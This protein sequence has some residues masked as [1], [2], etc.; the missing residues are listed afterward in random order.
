MCILYIVQYSAKVVHGSGMD[1]KGEKEAG[2]I[3]IDAHMEWV[4]A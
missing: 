2:N 1:G 4:S 3:G